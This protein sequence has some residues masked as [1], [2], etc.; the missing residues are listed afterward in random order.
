ML[1]SSFPFWKISYG[2]WN[3]NKYFYLQTIIFIVP[4]NKIL[5]DDNRCWITDN[6]VK[7]AFIHNYV[8]WTVP[9]IDEIQL[10]KYYNDIIRLY[11]WR[12]YIL[13][14][15]LIVVSFLVIV[16]EMIWD[17]DKQIQGHRIFY[18]WLMICYWKDGKHINHRLTFGKVTHLSLLLEKWF[19]TYWVFV[20]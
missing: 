17:L 14:R 3:W 16:H 18:H 15:I 12:K 4:W 13:F 1:W 2:N 19:S 6:R 10:M 8:M 20:F 9:L 5:I 7:Q 11:L